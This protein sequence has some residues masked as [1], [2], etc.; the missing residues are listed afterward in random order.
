[1]SER[2]GAVD[3]S[4]QEIATATATAAAEEEEIWSWGAGTDGQLGTW[5]LED[6]HLPQLLRLPSLT[7]LGPISMLACGGAHVIALTSGGKVLTWGR[8]TSGQLGHGDTLNSLSPKPVSFFHD[9]VITH[10]AAGWS[11]SGFVS[12]TSSLFTC[13]DGSFGQLGHSDNTSHCYPAKVSYFANKHVK[14]VACG[15]RHSLVLSTGFPGNQVHAF[16]SGKRGQLGVSSDLTKSINLPRVVSGLEGVEIVRI[17]ANGDHSAALSANGELFTWGRGFQGCTTDARTPQR[18]DSAVSFREIAL[19]WN[20]ALQLTGDG[21]VFMLG[22]TLN[23]QPGK[24]TDSSEAILEKVPDFEGLRVLKIA[25]GAEHS[26]AVTENGEV[27]TWG[28]GEHGQLGHGSAADR[29]KPQ[30]VN[31]GSG[32]EQIKDIEVYCGSGFTFAVVTR[33]HLPPPL[34]T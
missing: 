8:G 23:H 28:W 32:Y 19:G 1:M 14:M 21:E 4:R 5:R 16:G 25:A 10:V 26:A 27:R 30:V 17:S 11:H 12:D 13:G 20:H 33:K 9:C 24:P 31:L 7:S 22:K 3:E 18:L 34:I 15:M 29:T 6:E 2:D